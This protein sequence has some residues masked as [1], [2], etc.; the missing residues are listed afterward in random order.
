VTR[1]TCSWAARASGKSHRIAFQLVR[2]VPSTLLASVAR[3]TA[4][5]RAPLAGTV[6]AVT[7]AC[8]ITARAAWVK[9]THCS[10]SALVCFFVQ[11]PPVTGR[12]GPIARVGC[13]AHGVSPRPACRFRVGSDWWLVLSLLVRPGRRVFAAL[14]WL[15]CACLCGHE[16]VQTVFSHLLGS[17]ARSIACCRVSLAGSMLAVTKGSRIHCSHSLGNT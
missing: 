13:A 7:G 1:Q 3:P 6:L 8:I 15:L 17:V 14:S 9:R 11:K 4:S 10:V 12:F 2:A 16:R 5:R